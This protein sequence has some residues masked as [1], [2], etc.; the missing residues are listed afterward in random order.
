MIGGPTT[1][2]DENRRSAAG[3]GRSLRKGVG[4]IRGWS[5]L[6][7]I[8]PEGSVAG[9]P[10]LHYLRLVSWGKKGIDG[11]EYAYS[12]SFQPEAVAALWST[13]G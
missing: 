1:G 2:C 10:S 9:I 12:R 5:A 11:T 8:P 6:P 13:A 3:G 7:R 4:R